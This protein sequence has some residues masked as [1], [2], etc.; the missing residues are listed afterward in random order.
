MD[1]M[2]VN[3]IGDVKCANIFVQ[4]FGKKDDMGVHLLIDWY[5]EFDFNKISCL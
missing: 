2:K 1:I 4:I 5:V 3:D